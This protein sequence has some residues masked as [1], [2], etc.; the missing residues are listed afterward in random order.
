MDKIQL[1]G[2]TTGL[3]QLTKQS[4]IT[5][6]SNGYVITAEGMTDGKLLEVYTA[7]GTLAVKAVAHDGKATIDATQLAAGVYVVKAENQSLKMVK[8]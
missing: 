2:S 5:L 6:R 3:L 8:R 7:N 4:P 1:T